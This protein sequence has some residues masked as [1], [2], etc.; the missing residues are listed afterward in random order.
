VV[1]ANGL[2]DAQKIQRKMPWSNSRR[3]TNENDR[4]N[5][6]RDGSKKE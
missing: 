1:L 4:S 5:P 3:H 2:S 6:W